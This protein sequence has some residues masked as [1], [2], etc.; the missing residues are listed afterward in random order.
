[1][2][3]NICRVSIKMMGDN[4][5]IINFIKSKIKYIVLLVIC[6]ALSTITTHATIQFASP[7]VKYD[8]TNSGLQSTNVSDAIDELYAHASNYSSFSTQ[9]S[10]A[11]SYKSVIYPVGSIYMST[12]DSTAAAVAARFGGT[13]EAFAAGKNLLGTDVDDVDLSIYGDA[14]DTGGTKTYTLTSSN[15]NHTHE[16]SKVGTSTGGTALTQATTPSHTHTISGMSIGSSGSGSSELRIQT[17]GNAVI[18][19]SGGG[20]TWA[21]HTNGTSTCAYLI[22][23]GYVGYQTRIGTSSTALTSTGSGTTHS[24]TIGTRTLTTGDYGSDN[25][26]PISVM[27]SY[28]TVYMWKRIA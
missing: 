15:L 24:H 5:K 9:L 16:Y 22:G 8:N 28:V 14:G 3:G 2:K 12:T 10:A 6:L 7:N 27:D 25:P 20:T 17:D 18:Y 21:S 11:E 13:W 4:M 26:D 1:M 19:K 23:G